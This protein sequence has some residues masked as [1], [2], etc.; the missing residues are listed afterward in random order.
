[1][2]ERPSGIVER[3]FGAADDAGPAT[4]SVIAAAR[5]TPLSLTSISPVYTPVFS[6]AG[7]TLTLRTPGSAVDEVPAAGDTASHL[8]P[9]RVDADAWKFTGVKLLLYTVI[10][11]A[12]GV[13][14][15]SAATN[16]KPPGL[17]SG[18][19]TAVAGCTSSTAEKVCGE[20]CVFGAETVIS[21]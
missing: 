19:T 8:A 12:G 18:C 15:P 6:P 9:S 2:V 3:P 16:S 7:F 21:A 13:L 14:P 20:S 1:M 11:C 17:K 4:R 5:T 10:F